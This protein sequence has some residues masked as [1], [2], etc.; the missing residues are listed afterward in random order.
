MSCFKKYNPNYGNLYPNVAIPEEVLKALRKSDRR[1]RY[2]EY[3][4]K[5]G[6][7][8]YFNNTTCTRTDKRD[9]D[10]IEAESEQGVETSLDAYLELGEKSISSIINEYANPLYV[11]L[12]KE[13]ARELYRCLGLLKPKEIKLINALFF[14]NMTETEYANVIG[15]SQSSVNEMKH[16]IL[17]KL[18]ANFYLK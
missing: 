13:E 9:L 18:R 10:R 11:L 14:K 2:Y 12:K 6:K 5:C 8:V 17:S 3:D 16:R 7:P 15:R 1:L 4:I